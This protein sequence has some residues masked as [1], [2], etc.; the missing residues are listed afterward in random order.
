MKKFRKIMI[1]ILILVIFF[2]CVPKTEYAT[3]ISMKIGDINGDGAIDSRD[4][5]RILE[6]IAAST[7]PQIKQKHAEWILTEEKINYADINQDGIIDSRDTLREL[8]YIAAS[9]IP[10]IAQKHPDWKAYIENKWENIEVTEITL[11]RTSIKLEEGS[12]T[13]LMATILPENAT[14][15]IVTWSSSDSNVA[16]VDGIGNITGQKTGIAIITAKALNG[17]YKSCQVEVT[18]KE[19]IGIDPTIETLKSSNLK[20][21]ESTYSNNKTAEIPSTEPGINVG[22]I[23][24]QITE[25]SKKSTG[26]VLKQKDCTVPVGTS[27]QLNV[28]TNTANKKIT[29]SSSNSSIATVNKNGLV[30]GIKPGIIT[31]TAKTSN[32]EKATCIIRVNI[33]PKSISLNKTSLN[34]N[35]GSKNTITVNFNPTNTSS[36]EVNWKS[37]NPN[38]VSV[39]NATTTNGMI[40]IIAKAKGTATITATHKYGLKATCKVTVLEQINQQKPEIYDIVLFFGQSNMV[41]TAY[42]TIEK[43]Y[44]HNIYTY[45]GANSVENYSKMTGI[46]K[47]ILNNNGITLDFVSIKQAKNTVYEYMYLTNSFKEIDSTKKIQYGEDLVYENNRLIDYSKSSKKY[48]SL[49]KSNGTNMIPQF[50]QTYYKLT[51]HKVIAVFAAQGGV[52]IQT[53]LPHGDKRNNLRKCNCYMYEALKTKYKA[54]EKFA[55]E[56]QLKIGNK[57]YIIAQGEANTEFNTSTNTYKEIYMAVHKNLKRDL[58]IEKGA[59]VE[60]SY[61]AGNITMEQLNR[62]HIAQEEIIKKESDIILGSSY[63]YDRY[64]PIKSDY[65]NCNTKVTKSD[66]GKKL[67][68]EEALLRS[69]Y[70]VDPTIT[71]KS[72][73]KRN[74]IHFTSASLSQVGMETAINISKVIK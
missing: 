4:T 62:V 12:T 70:S 42:N 3:E 6:H 15:K 33:P 34:I 69:R 31:I 60:T 71:N 9:T 72:T 53:F 11:D 35:K 2:C 49:V 22:N 16:T 18:N 63:F 30:K 56:K 61:I 13:K 7:I 57:L 65:K 64:V 59:I 47:N 58:G 10:T 74:Y 67:P 51:G 40:T 19:E 5:L 41:G 32:N 45:A 50:C 14:N 48:K 20:T 44:N 68:Y 55:R 54:A 29:W 39:S 27:L 17:V 25:L 43:R 73:G 37:S 46:N 52:P 21:I 24:G 36:K 38:V 66:N 28:A 23:T 1:P 8:E 26:I